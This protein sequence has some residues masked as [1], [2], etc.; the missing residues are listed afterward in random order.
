MAEVVNL[1]LNN[2]RKLAIKDHANG[3]GN[4]QTFIALAKN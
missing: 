3:N 1:W 2:D 4:R